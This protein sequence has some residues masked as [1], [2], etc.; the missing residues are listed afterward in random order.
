MK[1]TC[2]TND[3]VRDRIRQGIG[4]YDDNLTKIKKHTLSGWGIYQDQQC[5]PRQFYKEQC[6]EGEEEANKGSINLGE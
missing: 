1:L 6:K 5:L 2:I 3:A 4:P